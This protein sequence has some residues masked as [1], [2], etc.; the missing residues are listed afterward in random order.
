MSY[1]E[2]LLE[3]ANEVIDSNIYQLADNYHELLSPEGERSREWL[4]TAQFDYDGLQ[5]APW[6]GFT[7]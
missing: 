5:A 4:Y 6:G 3:K 7:P 2:E 1:T